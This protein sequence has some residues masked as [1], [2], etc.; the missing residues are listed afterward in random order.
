MTHNR[1]TSA[2]SAKCLQF[3]TT[4]SERKKPAQQK[5]PSSISKTLQIRQNGERKGRDRWSVRD[6]LRW[7]IH[8]PGLINER[9][10]CVARFQWNMLEKTGS[11]ATW[12]ARFPEWGCLEI[13]ELDSTFAFPPP[14]YA[15]KKNAFPLTDFVSS[16]EM[17]LRPPQVQCYQPHHQ[18][19]RP[20]LCPDFHRKGRRKRPLHWWE[21]DLRSLRLYPF[22][23]RER[24]LLQPPYP[25]WRLPQE[26]LERQPPAINVVIEGLRRAMY[27]WQNYDG[28]A[29][30]ERKK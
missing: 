9:A 24:W 6:F 16:F 28:R 15:M 21:R 4:P 17:Q 20:R 26:C 3:H 12:V 25:A 2:T 10:A 23:W 29:N 22:P 19:Q 7:N 8:F 11:R 27:W 18:G 14:F 13:S 1:S 30:A 5:P